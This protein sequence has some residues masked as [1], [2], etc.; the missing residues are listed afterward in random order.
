MA[1]RS[2]DT[3]R[4][5]D[6]VQM[7]LL[8]EAGVGRRARMTLSL[9]GEVIGLARQAIRRTLQEPTDEEV[10]LRFV[11]LHYGLDLATDVRRFLAS[12]RH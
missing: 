5:A 12:R 7:A 2:A 3:D 4:E 8:R 6:D 11:E 10:G 9:S 1:L